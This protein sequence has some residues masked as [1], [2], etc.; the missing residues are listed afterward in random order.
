MVL[1]KIQIS[2]FIENVENFASLIWLFDLYY[3]I[4]C[5]I[6]KI[7]NILTRKVGIIVV[8]FIIFINSFFIN[9]NY[10]YLLYIYKRITYILYICV[11]PILFLANKKKS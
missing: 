3:L 9:N 5:T 11:L 2:S 10:E 6:N 8:L 7:N 4:T 1:K